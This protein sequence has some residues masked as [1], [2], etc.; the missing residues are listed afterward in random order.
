MFVTVVIIQR[1]GRE[2]SP[3]FSSWDKLLTQTFKHFFKMKITLQ[4]AAPML[5]VGILAFVSCKKDEPTPTELLTTGTCWKMT[6][7]EGYDSTNK[8]WVSVP[9]EDCEADNCFAFKT[10]QSFTVEEGALKCQPDDPQLSEGTWSLSEDGKK[11]SLSDD[12]DTE[13]GSIVELSKGKLVYELAFGE[14]K[15]RVTLV[16][17]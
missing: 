1:F 11:L 12:S 2:A 6:L 14:D 3:D 7:L 5:L 8:L 4:I 15:I 16:G 17:N 9:V 13:V 10:D